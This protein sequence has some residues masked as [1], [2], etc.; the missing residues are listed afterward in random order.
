MSADTKPS[1][2]KA[3]ADSISTARKAQIESSRW[4]RGAPHSGFSPLI[5]RIKSRFS[6]SIFWRPR[7]SLEFQCKHAR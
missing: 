5:F 4:I 7:R 6:H 2:L 3:K 1:A